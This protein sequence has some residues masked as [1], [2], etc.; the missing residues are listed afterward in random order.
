MGL[1]MF[2][3]KK[4]TSSN[5]LVENSYNDIPDYTGYNPDCPHCGATMRFSYNKSE[6]RCFECDLVMDENDWN[7]DSEDSSGM[8][9]VCST[10]GGPWPS[11]QTSC[12][13]FDE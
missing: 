2:G 11:C 7:H 4:D 12:K 8:P 3:K 10:C 1:F 9:F 5:D 6:F 13:M